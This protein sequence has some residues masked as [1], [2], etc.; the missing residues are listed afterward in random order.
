MHVIEATIHLT[1]RESVTNSSRDRLNSTSCLPQSY[2][3]P[4]EVVAYIYV[5]NL[6]VV[7]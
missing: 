1:Y 7:F 4:P 6:L 2:P 3:V 5:G